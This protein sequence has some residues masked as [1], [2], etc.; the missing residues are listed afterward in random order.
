MRRVHFSQMRL[1]TRSRFLY[2][3]L[4]GRWY[5]D[6]Y[7]SSDSYHNSFEN[8]DTSLSSI[9]WNVDCD[10]LKYICGNKCQK[11]SKSTYLS[12]LKPNVAV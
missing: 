4:G 5:E 10:L 9:D 1:V 6:W 2:N 11:E 8:V 12:G 3:G 7:I